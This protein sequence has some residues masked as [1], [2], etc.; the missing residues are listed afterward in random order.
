METKIFTTS[1]AFERE[2]KR[3]CNDYDNLEIY[4]AWVGNAKAI[5]PFEYLYSLKKINAVIGVAFYQTHPDGIKFLMDLKCDLRIA[6]ENT[7]YHPKIYIFSNQKRTSIFIGSSNFTY[8]GFYEN[9]EANVLIES[10]SNNEFITSIRKDVRK[11]RTKENS[12]RPDKSWLEKYTNLHEIRMAKLR[13]AGLKDET[14]VEETTAIP[15]VWLN[16]GDWSIYMKRVNNGLKIHSVKYEEN[17]K[18]KLA[19]LNKCSRD[20]SLP[21]KIDY[22]KFLEKRKLIGG[23]SPYG[24]LGHVAASGN[25]RRI[26][27]NGTLE[28]QS[29]IIKGINAI[30]ILQPP[31]DHIKLKNELK[32]LVNIG[33]TM[34]VWGRL[35]AIVRPDLFC[36]ISAPHVRKNISIILGVSEKSIESVEGY[37]MLLR[38]IH[39]SPWFNSEAPKNKK[40]LEIWKRRVAFL[41]VVFYD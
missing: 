15:A 28:E 3:C 11:W 20:L 19:L 25:F 9:Q 41:D 8:H 32:K 14:V 21:W 7:L 24:W 5:V 1:Y 27:K 2:F 31:L 22:F 12:F 23:M 18:L 39:S 17:L 40:E 30:S 4:V 38:L 6:K 29:T 33:P 34:K 10:T 36:T 37:L 26:M 16:K 35:L 13:E